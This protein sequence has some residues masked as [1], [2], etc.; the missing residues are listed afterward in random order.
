MTQLDTDP[1][2]QDVPQS[3]QP[4][5]DHAC[6]VEFIWSDGRKALVLP[7][8]YLISAEWQKFPE[9]EE[10]TCNWGPWIVTITGYGLRDVPGRLVKGGID[11][12]TEVRVYQTEGLAGQLVTEMKAVLKKN[13]DDN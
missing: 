12:I 9:R 10:V 13:R 6:Y 3:I 4:S 8:V 1:F 7:T 11:S 2:S 5:S